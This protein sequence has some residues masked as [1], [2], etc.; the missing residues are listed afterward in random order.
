MDEDPDRDV[1]ERAL[2]RLFEEVK[3]HDAVLT[4]PMTVVK[5]MF[6]GRRLK[7]LGREQIA[8]GLLRRNIGYVGAMPSTEIGEI[9]LYIKETP[10]ARVLEAAN[11]PLGSKGDFRLRKLASSNRRLQNEVDK[12]AILRQ[13]KAIIDKFEDEIDED[14]E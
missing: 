3:Q 4:V 14:E 2:R 5:E 11:I 10:V 1:D 13:L 8:N 9:R 12:Q 6:G 7:S